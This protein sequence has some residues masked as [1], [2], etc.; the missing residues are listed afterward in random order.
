MW[1]RE[2]HSKT[3]DRVGRAQGQQARTLAA[4]AT[5]LG[6]LII[7]LH[8][9]EDGTEPTH[10]VAPSKTTVRVGGRRALCTQAHCA[11]TP[12]VAADDPRRLRLPASKRVVRAVRLARV[13]RRRRATAR[14][15][16]TATESG[17]EEERVES[18]TKR[19]HLARARATPGRY[20]EWRGVGRP[21][22]RCEP[23]APTL[24]LI[25]LNLEWKMFTKRFATCRFEVARLPRR[26]RPEDI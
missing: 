4:R 15:I 18:A 6:S 5:R 7:T 26:G 2:H 12:A 13:P 10:V 21:P 22:P 11:T 20:S 9:T 19:S 14:E 8:T 23:V 1:H 17:G 25:T 24:N 3:Y 16:L